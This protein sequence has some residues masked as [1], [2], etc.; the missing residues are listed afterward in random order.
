MR[1]RIGWAAIVA[2][3]LTLV[4]PASARAAQRPGDDDPGRLVEEKRATPR[5]RAEAWLCWVLDRRVSKFRVRHRLTLA[6]ARRLRLAGLGDIKHGLDELD[7]EGWPRG[8]RLFV[9]PSPGALTPGMDEEGP[10]GDGSL[11]A[12]VLAKILADRK[13]EDAGR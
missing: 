9:I 11:F 4:S 6:E 2:A 8:D 12:K 5:V 7:R 1:N 10:F 13:A 3:G